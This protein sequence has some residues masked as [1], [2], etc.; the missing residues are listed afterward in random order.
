MN[1]W[2]EMGW[3]ESVVTKTLS[4][5]YQM[6]LMALES[7]KKLVTLLSDVRVIYLY[8]QREAIDIFN[9]EKKTINRKS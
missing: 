5:W 9:A 2:M 3:D 8:V 6:F 7:F 1:V 4:E